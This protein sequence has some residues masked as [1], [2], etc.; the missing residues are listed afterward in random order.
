MEPPGAYD[1]P[2]LCTVSAYDGGAE[3]GLRAEA[4][5][6]E[7]QRQGRARARNVG[8]GAADAFCRPQAASDFR[9]AAAARGTG[10]RTG[11]T[12]E[13]SAAGRAAGRTGQEAA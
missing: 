11:T 13:T 4:R 5:T 12:A 1:V 7:P 10:P 2:V 3:R 8:T 9:G 6:D